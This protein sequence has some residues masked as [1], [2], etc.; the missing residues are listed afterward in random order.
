[1]S[2]TF[3][4]DTREIICPGCKGNVLVHWSSFIGTGKK[5]PFCKK[6]IYYDYYS[7]KI[8]VRDPIK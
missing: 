3:V 6:V 5:C 2:G 8:K 4:T 7:R 1:M